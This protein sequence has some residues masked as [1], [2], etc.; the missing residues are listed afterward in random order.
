MQLSR[1]GR[2][3]LRTPSLRLDLT[4]I[5]NFSQDSF[6]PL[7]RREALTLREG[8]QESAVIVCHC[9]RTTDREIRRA[10]REGA[11]TL[12]DVS[13]RCGAASGCGG[14]TEAVVEI[15]SAELGSAMPRAVDVIRSSVLS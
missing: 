8:P 10:V 2:S 7:P 6:T 4:L 9:R 15:L 5:F 1:T 12:R 13:T 11:T 14:C 3:Y